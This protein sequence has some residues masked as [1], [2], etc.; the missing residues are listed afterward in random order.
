MIIN[1]FL[2]IMASVTA[3]MNASVDTI[4]E[5][6]AGIDLNDTTR[7]DAKND[8][9]EQALQKAVDRFSKAAT[10]DSCLAEVVKIVGKRD[11]P[12][13]DRIE[14]FQVLGWWCVAKK[15]EFAVGDLVVY[16]KIGAVLNPVNPNY[17]FLEGKPIKTKKIRGSISQGF[18]M[19]LSWIPC[20]EAGE[21][22]EGDDVTERV[23]VMKYIEPEE[24]GLY[25][26]N[27]KNGKNGLKHHPECIPKTDEERVQNLRSKHWDQLRGQ[28][29]HKTRKED[30]TSGTYYFNQGAFG[31]CSR[32]Y[33]LEAETKDSAHFF[34]ME[35]E[36]D[37]K[38]GLTELGR[39]IA[40]RGEVVGPGINGNRLKL[41]KLDFRVFNIWN[42]DTQQYLNHAEV[43]T[44]C[45][46]LGLHTVPDMGDQLID[47]DDML[48]AEY[49]INL[50][51][52][53][54][55]LAGVPAEGIVIKTDSTNGRRVSFKAISNVYLIKYNK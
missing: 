5:G 1:H 42:I 12:D 16:V 11:I 2:I 23:G 15:D 54:E 17:T 40:I 43:L 51:N 53:T 9:A 28:T 21:Y 37:I 38:K 32:N 35:R 44:I 3:T 19:P 27:D 46:Q 24:S 34:K 6:V 8:A 14:S 25:G 30:G 39:N 7:T 13:A 52:A 26:K 20:T 48:T 41:P 50:A 36:F 18:I 55:Y 31:M 4:T 47:S 45:V 10:P 29:V 22:K 49:W 33:E